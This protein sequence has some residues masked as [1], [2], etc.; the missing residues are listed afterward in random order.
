MSIH[1]IQYRLAHAD[2][3]KR[4]TL[5]KICLTTLKCLYSI[6]KKYNRVDIVA[7]SY[8]DVSIKT[9]ERQKR[10]NSSKV[11]ARFVKSKVLRHI[12]NFLSDS[13]NKTWLIKGT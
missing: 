12:T 1:C 7:D 3:S 10:G 8:R 11:Y 6:P 4:S 5:Y 9:A 13:E 2:G